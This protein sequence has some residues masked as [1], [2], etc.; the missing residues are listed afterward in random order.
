[1]A[2]LPVYNIITVPDS[3]IYF[4]TE[5][6]RVMTDKIPVVG[7]KITLIV[8]KED[9]SRNQFRNDS[10]CP[11]GLNGFIT[12]VHSEGY[13]VAHMDYR[14]NVSEINV[15]PDQT[16]GLFAERRIDIPDL[17]QEYEQKRLHRIKEDILRFSGNFQWGSMAHAY[18]SK[19]QSVSEI[20]SSLSPWIINSN[21]ERYALLAE[22]S[23]KTRND[24][25]EKMIYENVEMA[26]VKNRAK[27]AQEQDYQ[28]IYKESAIKK[29]IEY[30][31]KELDEMHPEDVSDLRRL[32]MKLEDTEMNEDAKK[33]GRKI[34][35]RLK[36]ERQH[37]AET[38][39]LQDYLEFLVSLP[40]K[41]EDAGF[42]QLDEAK[43]ILDEDHSG[44]K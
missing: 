37:G 29:Q 15:F 31:Q 36:K 30:L 1:M 19:W 44:L 34:L 13:A 42:I 6:Y 35:N 43:R 32:E 4:R 11:V 22:D 40:W 3:N 18:I 14:V 5:Y 28:K 24:L 26:D 27:S 39:M 17:D 2:I 33:E 25:I 12:E 20:I 41:K 16:I 23:L 9:L 10:F 8:L 21:N 7:E 38:G